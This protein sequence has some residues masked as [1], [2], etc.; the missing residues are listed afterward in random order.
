[1]LAQQFEA[2]FRH[3]IGRSTQTDRNTVR[4]LMGQC[5]GDTFT[6]SQGCQ[7]TLLSE[8]GYDACTGNNRKA[9]GWWLLRAIHTCEYM[10]HIC[11]SYSQALCGVKGLCSDIYHIETVSIVLTKTNI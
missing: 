5:S 11:V 9:V 7:S 4:L 6:G 2:F 8:E 3:V 1:M 10:T